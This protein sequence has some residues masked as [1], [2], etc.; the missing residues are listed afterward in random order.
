MKRHLPLPHPGQGLLSEG[1]VSHLHLLGFLRLACSHH[2]CSWLWPATW[3]C[4]THLPGASDPQM[5]TV[6]LRTGN[7]LSKEKAGVPSWPSVPQ[8][9]PERTEPGDDS[10]AVM[11]LEAVHWAQSVPSEQSVCPQKT[12]LTFK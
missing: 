12:F 10:Q 9:T 8:N 4:L 1:R 3:L 7:P 11:K 5:V 6:N 2:R